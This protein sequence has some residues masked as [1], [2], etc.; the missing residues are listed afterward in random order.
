MSYN[1]VKCLKYDSNVK[2]ST[3]TETWKIPVF[4]FLPCLEA[5]YVFYD[6]RECAGIDESFEYLEKYQPEIQFVTT[7][8]YVDFKNIEHPF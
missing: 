4:T 1:K 3:M 6:D 5:K 2:G 7:I 8:N